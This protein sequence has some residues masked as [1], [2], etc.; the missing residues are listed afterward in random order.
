MSDATTIHAMVAMASYHQL[1]LRETGLPPSD[2]RTRD[3][4]A[5]GRSEVRHLVF[6]AIH[7]LNKKF[8]NST[9]ALSNSSIMSAS[10]LACC[11]VC[12]FSDFLCLTR[13]YISSGSQVRLPDLQT[14][15]Q[16]QI[17]WSQTILAKFCNSM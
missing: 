15:T 7:F 6:E 2:W 11:S 12:T 4:L 10:L 8:R 1:F 13:D 17:V 16:P 9:E 3:N 14:V 5:N